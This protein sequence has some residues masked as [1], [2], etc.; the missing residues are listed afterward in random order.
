MFS[1]LP[2]AGI[3]KLSVNY[4][5]F[6]SEL[7][8]IS[9]WWYV[10]TADGLTCNFKPKTSVPKWNE[11]LRHW[12]CHWILIYHNY[13]F[14]FYLPLFIFVLVYY[15][16]VNVGKAVCKFRSKWGCNHNTP[17]FNIWKFHGHTLCL[18]PLKIHLFV[19]LFTKIYIILVVNVEWMWIQN[20]HYILYTVIQAALRF[21]TEWRIK[22]LICI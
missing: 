2:I 12:K 16:F 11:R 17:S 7:K 10:K 13:Y 15:K 14:I 6:S 9:N 3:R 20:D 8:A 19:L 21:K 4:S 22:T 1:Q 5:Y 18:W